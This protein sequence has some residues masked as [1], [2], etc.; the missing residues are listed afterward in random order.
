MRPF[1]RHLFSAAALIATGTGA[2]QAQGTAYALST[3]PQGSQPAV[4]QLIRFNP[5][6][7]GSFTTVGVTGVTLSGIDFRPLNNVLSGYAGTTLYTINL[8]TGAAT[9]I[10]GTFGSASGN[11]GFDFNPTVDR[12]RVVSPTGTNLRLTPDG[13]M[14]MPT[15]PP[16]SVDGAYTLPASLGGGSP[17][18]SAVAYTNN[19]NDPLTATM[20][21]GIDAGRGQLFRMGNPNGGE[22]TLIGSLGISNLSSVLGFD[23][24]TVGTTNTA[25]F[26]ANT[27]AASSGF[28]SL[29]LVTGAATLV[30]RFGGQTQITGLAITA[31]PEP[32][33]YLLVAVGL[34]GVGLVARRRRNVAA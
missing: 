22:V 21:F 25:F 11:A 14:T 7:P 27:N 3:T 6:A 10:P 32:G 29:D 31:V 30:D 9:A 4:Q 5:S 24:V 1:I 13:N 33:T 20:L 26:T 12:I 15:P 16:T 2:A 8:Q 23:I 19:D 17:A 28:Y 34:A 18:F